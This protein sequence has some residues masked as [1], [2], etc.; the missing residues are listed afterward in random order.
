VLYPVISL[1]NEEDVRIFNS[2]DTDPTWRGVARPV[3]HYKSTSVIP[4]NLLSEGVMVL[5]AEMRTETPYM[6]HFKIDDLLSFQAIR[7][8]KMLEM[9]REFSGIRP[10]IVQPELEWET[11]YRANGHNS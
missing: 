5:G 3:G 8:G 7:G 11:R 10:G 4:A 1:V 2:V 9:R 6:L